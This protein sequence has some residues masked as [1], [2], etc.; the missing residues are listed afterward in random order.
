MNKDFYAGIITA[1]AVVHLHDEPTIY[2]EII[3]SLGADIDGLINHAAREG[4]LEFAGLVANGYVVAK[5]QVAS[6]RS[7][8]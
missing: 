2:R 5:S 6:E 7:E 8:R 4:E 3:E 1:L